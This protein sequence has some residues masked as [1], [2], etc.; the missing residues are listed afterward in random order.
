[1]ILIEMLDARRICFFVLYDYGIQNPEAD[2]RELPPHD[3]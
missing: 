1:M 2:R 3:E